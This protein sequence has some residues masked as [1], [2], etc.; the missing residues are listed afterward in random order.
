MKNKK[1]S[2]R[3]ANQQNNN[4]NSSSNHNHAQATQQHHS[5]HHLN[6]SLNMGHHAAKMHQ[7]PLDNSSAGAMGFATY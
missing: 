6:L 2:Q 4:N 1:N 5:G 7:W 3:Q